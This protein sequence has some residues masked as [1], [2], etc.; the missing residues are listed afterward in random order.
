[1]DISTASGR[2]FCRKRSLMV[3]QLISSPSSFAC[4]LFPCHAC[5]CQGHVCMALSVMTNPDAFPI[6]SV[7]SKCLS[8]LPNWQSLLTTSG[9]LKDVA[10]KSEYVFGPGNYRGWPVCAPSRHFPWQL[11]SQKGFQT[12]PRDVQH[13]QETADWKSQPPSRSVVSS[14]WRRTFNSFPSLPPYDWARLGV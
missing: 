9:Q 7:T 1:M 11:P 8:I 12:E 3:L 14:S 13:L 5:W 10:W 6:S 2:L 4:Q